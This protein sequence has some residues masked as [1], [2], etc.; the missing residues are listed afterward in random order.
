MSR[1]GSFLSLSEEVLVLTSMATIKSFFSSRGPCVTCHEMEKADGVCHFLIAGLHIRAQRASA[2]L[3]EGKQTGHISR[4]TQHGLPSS[5][6]WSQLTRG[7]Y[8]LK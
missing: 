8:V 2:V 6:L 4:G 3:T 1:H 5:A 7:I